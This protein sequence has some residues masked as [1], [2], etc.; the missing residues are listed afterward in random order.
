[1]SDN[2][3][4]ELLKI[5]AAK[6]QAE[7]D[8][9]NQRIAQNRTSIKNFENKLNRIKEITEQSIRPFV[10][11]ANIILSEN[12]GYNLLLND[13][14]LS[15]YESTIDNWNKNIERSNLPLN[16]NYVIQL[17]IS[18]NKNN[19]KTNIP[20]KRNRTPQ[21]MIQF[22]TNQEEVQITEVGSRTKPQPIPW[23]EM[24]STITQRII[25]DLI[26]SNI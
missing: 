23:K 24:N 15:N 18:L 26:E 6:K 1:M 10:D 20:N 25:S 3:K 5:I 14:N 21:L 16:P 2:F 8:E 12:L 13:A 17:N 7:D 9:I 11:E 22:Y 19:T 4:K